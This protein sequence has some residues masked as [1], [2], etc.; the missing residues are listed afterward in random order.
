MGVVTVKMRRGDDE[1]GRRPGPRAPDAPGQWS[2]AAIEQ[3]DA[4]HSPTVGPYRL[5]RLIGGGGA[6]R[7]YLG[8]GPDG[9]RVAVKVAGPDAGGD[10]LR[11]EGAACAAV[12][13]PNVVQLV[14]RGR[15]GPQLHLV[16]EYVDGP[17]FGQLVRAIGEVPAPLVA[18]YARQA[19]SGLAALHAAGWVHRDVKPTNLMRS[20]DGS[21]KLVDV[22]AAGRID[23]AGRPPVGWGTVPCP[24]P[25]PARRPE[26]A[27]PQSDV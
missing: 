8:L 7:V 11:L 21:V 26:L 24:A 12:D 19:A 10:D 17:T 14:D 27:D 23:G 4:R 6:G 18:E 13:H 1:D 2:L 22:G 9:Q 5:I 25:E 3:P 20:P 15:D 16:L